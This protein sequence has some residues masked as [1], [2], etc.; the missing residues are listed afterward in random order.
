LGKNAPNITFKETDENGIA[1]VAESK[2]NSKR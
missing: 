2:I 1:I